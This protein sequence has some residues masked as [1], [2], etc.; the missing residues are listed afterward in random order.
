MAILSLHRE[1][2][3]STDELFKDRDFYFILLFITNS[4]FLR[5][6]HYIHSGVLLRG[7]EI[8]VV[9][10]VFETGSHYHITLN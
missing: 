3:G 1:T 2:L 4:G 9:W 7:W 10:F 5:R 6:Q 8:F